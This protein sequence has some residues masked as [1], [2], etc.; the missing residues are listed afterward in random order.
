MRRHSHGG[1]YGRAAG[2]VAPGAGNLPAGRP[3]TRGT[4]DQPPMVLGSVVDTGIKATDGT[5]VLYAV[6]IKEKVLKNTHFGL[7]LGRKLPDG[8]VT[9]DVVTNETSGP[10]KAAGF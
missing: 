1:Y 9:A 10:D 3:A 2:K 6:P 8:T 4:A 7:M 5:W